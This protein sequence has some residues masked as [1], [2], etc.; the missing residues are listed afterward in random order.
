[1]GMSS[2]QP[3]VYHAL[4]SFADELIDREKDE[5]EKEKLKIRKRNI[6]AN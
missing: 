5:K 4:I 1:M 2:Q 6:L 3:E